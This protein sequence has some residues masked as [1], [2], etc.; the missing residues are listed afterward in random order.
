MPYQ[1][2]LLGCKTSLLLSVKEITLSGFSENEMKQFI[3]RFH[4]NS[5]NNT[6]FAC[7]KNVPSMMNILNFMSQSLGYDVFSTTVR[8]DESSSLDKTHFYLRKEV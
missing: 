7:E 1:H 8:K 3:N 2:I 6:D 4:F 5:Y